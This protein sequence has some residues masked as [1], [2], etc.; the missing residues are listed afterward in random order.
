MPETM[1]DYLLDIAPSCMIH[2]DLQ[3]I[4]MPVLECAH[5]ETFVMPMYRD[6]VECKSDCVRILRRLILE[7]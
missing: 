2:N 5:I 6:C 7:D 3:T 1:V 4:R